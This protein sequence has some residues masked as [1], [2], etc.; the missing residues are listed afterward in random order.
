MLVPHSWFVLG[1]DRR[2]WTDAL[3][4]AALQLVEPV[5]AER[6][7]LLVRRLHRGEPAQGKEISTMPVWTGVKHDP[8]VC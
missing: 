4:A 3:V 2:V 8:R 5:S 7:D 6:L 1:G